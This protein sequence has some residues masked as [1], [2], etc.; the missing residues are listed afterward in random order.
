M[1]VQRTKIFL[2]ILLFAVNS[3][4]SN[5]H[6]QAEADTSYGHLDFS[7][8]NTEQEAFLWKRIKILAFEEAL[9]AHCGHPDDFEQR[10]RRAIQACV[11]AEALSKADSFY[12][13]YLRK[14]T[15]HIIPSAR[16]GFVGGL[17]P[18]TETGGT[19]RARSSRIQNMIW[20]T[21]SLKSGT[22]ARSANLRSGPFFAIEVGKND[23][24]RLSFS[25]ANLFAKYLSENKKICQG[26]RIAPL[27]TC[28]SREPKHD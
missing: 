15:E 18:S 16:S 23:Q 2:S 4:C 6:A 11:T 14:N 28:G 19:T 27:P 1:T 26:V 22:C 10:A 13:I 3:L 9:I 24:K 17:S 20:T 25:P 5:S 12:K 7:K 21:S 8:L